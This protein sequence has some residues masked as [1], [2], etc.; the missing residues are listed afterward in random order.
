MVSDTTLGLSLHHHCLLQCFARVSSQIFFLV[1]NDG[2]GR[3]S[4]MLQFIS[5][6]IILTVKIHSG[7]TFEVYVH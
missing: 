4:L 5:F 1:G 7:R 6:F 2:E 3:G